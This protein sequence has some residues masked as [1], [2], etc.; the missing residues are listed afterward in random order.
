[1]PPPRHI[2]IGPYSFALR[3]V[4][5]DGASVV[6]PAELEVLDT[7]RAERIRKKG[8]KVL[9]K[10]RAHSGRRTLSEG[11]LRHLTE[12]LAGFD[13]EVTLERIPDPRG[14]T[15]ERPTRLAATPGGSEGTQPDLTAG[16][17][18]AEVNRLAT[19]RVAAEETSRG[20]TLT[21]E[22]RDAAVATLREDPLIREAARVR[23]DAAGA[24]RDRMLSE[25][26]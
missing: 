14:V 23:V 7:A 3:A 24:E 21:P 6:G 20:I 2:N 5:T 25:L 19:L 22:Q 26:F 11:E 12:T 4:Y 8:H 17:F 13:R 1:M 16:E 9:E 10:L 15:T 18:D